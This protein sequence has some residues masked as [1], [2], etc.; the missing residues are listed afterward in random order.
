MSGYT[1]DPK[2]KWLIDEFHNR[3]QGNPSYSLRAFA[4]KLNLSPSFLSQLFMGKKDLS[5]DTRH[6]IIEILNLEREHVEKINT[7]LLIHQRR[8]DGIKGVVDR[9]AEYYHGD[10]PQRRHIDV[11]DYL[12]IISW[13]HDAIFHAIRFGEQGSSLQD[14]ADK[15]DF[16][17]EVLGPALGRLI[18]KQLVIEKNGRYYRHISQYSLFADVG[19]HQLDELKN[20]FLQNHYELLDRLGKLYKQPYPYFANFTSHMLRVPRSKINALHLMIH[21]FGVQIDEFFN[22]NKETDDDDCVVCCFNAQSVSL[23]RP[24]AEDKWYSEE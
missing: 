6:R 18:D 11:N 9:L 21:D 5:E 23:E 20:G 13:I 4:R 8:V 19:S 2:I 15:L 16:A 3:K 22:H 7:H 14:I 1:K 12:E 10:S 24:R 17:P